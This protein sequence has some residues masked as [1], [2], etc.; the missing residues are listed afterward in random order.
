ME[1][2]NK[3]HTVSGPLMRL[4]AAALTVVALLACRGELRLP[5]LRLPIIRPTHPYTSLPTQQPRQGK[6]R[7]PF[8]PIKWM[9]RL[10]LREIRT[11]IRRFGRAPSPR[12]NYENW[13]APGR[14][15][16]AKTRMVTRSCI[17]PSSGP[18]LRRFRFWLTPAQI[19]APETPTAT[20]FS[21]PRSGGIRSSP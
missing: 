19:L 15:S 2:R 10:R 20:R 12:T 1:Y 17:P 8:P 7:G 9:K 4:A 18:S 16:T 21:T 6:P 5:P 3:E 13:S 11:S 14:R